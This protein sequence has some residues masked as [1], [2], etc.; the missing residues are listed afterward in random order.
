MA[1]V[2]TKPCQDCKDQSC[3][4]VCP[5]D[6]IHEGIVERKGVTY[7]QLFINPES[8][9]CCSLC[10]TECPVDAIYAEDEVPAAWNQYVQ[11]NADFFKQ[12]KA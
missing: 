5:V 8:C 11:I 6:A 7:N 3:V 10:E 12:P 9:I 2:I 1:L 4:P